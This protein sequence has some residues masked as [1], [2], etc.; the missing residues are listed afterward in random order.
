MPPRLAIQP[1]CAYFSLSL[2]LS[3]SLQPPTKTNTSSASDELT[4]FVVDVSGSMCVS[5]EVPPGFGLIQLKS[6][7][8]KQQQLM[9]EF[10]AEGSQRLPSQKSDAVYL[11]RLA[12]MQ[13]EFLLL[14]LSLSLLFSY[15]LPFNSCYQYA[16]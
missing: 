15:Y 9:D 5:S 3:L 16:T 11:S 7:T 14:S 1:V 13:G 8:E 12:C 10:R 6:R 4:I 2:S